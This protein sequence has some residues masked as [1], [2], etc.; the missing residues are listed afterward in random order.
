MRAKT[1]GAGSG[2][3][4]LGGTN[5]GWWAQTDRSKYYVR[6]AGVSGI[7]EAVPETFPSKMTIYDYKFQFDNYGLSYLANKPQ[8]SRIIGQV[9]VPEPCDITMNFEELMVD[10]LGELGPAELVDSPPKKLD[11]WDAVIQPLT[12]FFAPTADSS[13]GNAQR[14]LCMGLTTH[15]ANIDQTLSGILGFMADGNLGTPAD[16]IE[17]VVSRLSTPSQIEL[18]GPGD[19]VYYF[20]PVAMPYYNDYASSGDT[21]SS[22]GWINFI[23]N[24][25]VAFFSDLPVHFHTSASTNS[26]VA[27]I[28]MTG[29]WEESGATFFN[30]DDQAGFDTNNIG[31]PA[32]SVS[33]NDYRNPPNPSSETYRT[34]AQR[35]WLNV[36]DLD[37]PL[38]W[39]FAAKSFKSPETEEVDL[40]VLDI[41]HQTDYLSAD[42]AEISFGVQYDGMPQINL[43]NMAFNAI[44]EAT[45]MASAFANS[46]G[47]AVHHAVEEGVDAMDSTLSDLPEE[48]FDPIFEEVLDP[49]VDDFYVALSNAYAATPDVDYYSGVVS[50][51]ILGVTGPVDENIDYL[52]RNLADNASAATNLIHNIDSRLDDAVGMIDGFVGM[53]PDGTN[54]ALPGILFQTNGEYETLSDLGV[55]ILQVLANSLYSSLQ[56]S[57]EEELSAVLEDAQPSLEAIT[58]VMT[59]LRGVITNV[60]AQLDVAGSFT[61]ELADALDSPLLDSPLDEITSTLNEYLGSLP[62]NGA[63]FDEYSPD[64]VKSLLRQKITDEFY[65][66]LPCAEVQEIIRSRLY[67]VDAAIRESID[68]AFQQLNKAMRDMASEYLSGI[69]DEINGLLGDLSDIMGSG[70][71]DGYAH[72]RGDSLTELR[73]DGKFQW[74]VPDEMSFNAYLIIKQLDSSSAGGCGALGEVLPE[75][76]L[77]TERF[78]ISWLGSDIKSDIETKFAFMI[79]SNGIPYLIGLAGS[80]DM[81][82]GEIGFESFTIN[83]L[84]AGVAFGLLENYLSANVRCKFTSYEVEGGVFFGRACSLDPFSWDPEVQSVLG[85]PPFT[86]V[87][88]YGEGWMPIV[89]YGCLF[90]IK[91]G[92]GAGIFAFVDGPVGGK[93]FMGANGEALCVVSVG[94]EV[95]LVGAKDGDDLRMKGKGKISGRAGAC[96][97]CVKFSKTVTME[98]NNGSWSADY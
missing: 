60:Q 75:V 80:F 16:Q 12:L 92:V 41:E 64:E 78:G 40:M 9:D 19:E 53:V 36:V 95:T 43:A 18:D 63:T 72:I 96:P 46:I 97:F 47:D 57:I 91:A 56:G 50:Q 88:V 28:Y 84:Y 82:E 48:L 7:H 3:S 77:G 35:Y 68:S 87:Y 33:K 85:D 81:V 24:L 14:A 55:G 44:D 38:E 11:Y 42:N 67:E 22:N 93:I 70:E 25:D 94:G 10:C 27:P 52:F 17:G 66:S 49:L 30:V 20:N 4:I 65:G 21:M 8:E 15:C 71:I 89:D 13:C 5:T 76:T 29:G 2:H 61:T 62:S 39:S 59:D 31:F 86:G 90:R 79:D 73:L 45:G 74:E 58:D 54:A 51:Y 69:D 34:R 26:A 32:G 83:E 98:Y 23:G 1:D 37:Y 6:W